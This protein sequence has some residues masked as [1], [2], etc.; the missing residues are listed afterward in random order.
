MSPTLRS[1][2]PTMLAYCSKNGRTPPPICLYL[3]WPLNT[4]SA[5]SPPPIPSM[6]RLAALIRVVRSLVCRARQAGP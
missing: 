6:Q 4:Q 2:R 5:D 1:D 3:M